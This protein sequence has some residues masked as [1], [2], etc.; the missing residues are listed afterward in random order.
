MT[1]FKK[2][3]QNYRPGIAEIHSAVRHYE[4]IQKNDINPA[5]ITNFLDHASNQPSKFRTITWAETNV[6]SRGVTNVNSQSKFKTSMLT[7]SLYDYSD[8]YI[9]VK[10]TAPVD[11]TSAAVAAVNNTNKKGI[12]KN[13]APFTKCINKIDNTQ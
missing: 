13:C 4:R 5:E 9:L 7:S 3:D 10:G 12:F 2:P 8:A 1:H 6:E 11:D